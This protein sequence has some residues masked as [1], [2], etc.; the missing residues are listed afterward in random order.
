[1]INTAERPRVNIKNLAIED[2]QGS[3]TSFHPDRDI[4]S[5]DWQ[6]YDE[7]KNKAVESSNGLSLLTSA[8][9]IL[10]D[11]FSTEGLAE[12]DWHDLKMRW[13][14]ATW[15]R[16]NNSE[17]YCLDVCKYHYI[18]PHSK[19]ILWYDLVWDKFKGLFDGRFS[20][21]HRYAL[22]ALFL[23]PDNLKH[24]KP[25]DELLKMIGGELGSA[26]EHDLT[27]VYLEEA[28]TARI[29]YPQLN[30]SQLFLT[31]E[32]WEEI[33]DVIHFPSITVSSEEITHVVHHFERLASATILAAKEAKI[34]KQGL[35]LKFD[36][37]V[38]EEES[39]PVP[40]VRRF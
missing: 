16:P 34:T 20:F 13:E 26:I 32:V 18:Y 9:I 10:G 7:W 3:A 19:D 1:M 21:R 27:S 38:P 11:K 36:D 33:M 25:D 30:T 12:P 35:E 37:L 17:Q 23:S 22:P 28:A 8:K 2:P 14:E 31:P 6:W 40:Q 24:M 4:T 29:L 39:S 5:E 15:G